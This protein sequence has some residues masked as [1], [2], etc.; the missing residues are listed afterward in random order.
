MVFD[1]NDL[2]PLDE[3]PGWRRITEP[4]AGGAL[5][6]VVTVTVTVT[7]PKVAATAQ[8]W[9]KVADQLAGYR[10]ALVTVGTSSRTVATGEA[11]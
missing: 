10:V 7:R 4:A 1:P 5:V 2:V 8:V 11:W 6:A 9:A 3:R